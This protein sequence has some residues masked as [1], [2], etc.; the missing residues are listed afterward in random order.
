M[1]EPGSVLGKEAGPMLR[2]GIDHKHLGGVVS[3][4]SN[5]P[6][7]HHELDCC[8]SLLHDERVGGVQN[9]VQPIHA[10]LMAQQTPIAQIDAE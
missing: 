4:Y 2:V 6:V 10:P 9:Y 1:L 3:G 8:G 5:L 7:R